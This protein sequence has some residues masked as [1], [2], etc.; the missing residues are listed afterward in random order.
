[1]QLRLLLMR[2]RAQRIPAQTESRPEALHCRMPRCFGWTDADPLP[3]MPWGMQARLPH[4][5]GPA[6]PGSFPVVRQARCPV[7]DPFNRRFGRPGLWQCSRIGSRPVRTPEFSFPKSAGTD[8][9]SEPDPIR[10]YRPRI[11]P[12]ARPNRVPHG[13]L[14][15]V[16]S[17]ATHSRCCAGRTCEWSAKYHAKHSWFQPMPSSCFWN[18]IERRFS[19]RENP[20]KSIPALS[21][22]RIGLF[23]IPDPSCQSRSVH[24]RPDWDIDSGIESGSNRVSN[25]AHNRNWIGLEWGFDLFKIESVFSG[26]D[27][28][29]IRTYPVRLEKIE[30]D[31][32]MSRFRNRKKL[33]WESILALFTNRIGLFSRNHKSNRAILVSESILALFTYR[34]GLFSRNHDREIARIAIFSVME[35]K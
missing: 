11:D 22:N 27:S 14:I 8:S 28:V 30:S 35:N 20:W 17:C 2:F 13:A 21:W 5:T 25:R 31:S 12:H 6:C 23:S 34:I 16:A 18:R 1:M 29:S 26:I 3:C 33:V 7:P 10:E 4:G 15:H 32:I 9:R 19:G 24:L